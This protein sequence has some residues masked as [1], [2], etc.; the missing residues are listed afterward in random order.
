M[1]GGFACTK[2]TSGAQA[3]AEVC[4]AHAHAIAVV[5]ALP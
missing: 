2:L 3:E 5:E 1:H 4:M